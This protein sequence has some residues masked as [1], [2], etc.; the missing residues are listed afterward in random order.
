[1]KTTTTS[2]T[3]SSVVF[4][5]VLLSVSVSWS[6]VS[7]CCMRCLTFRYLIRS[8]GLPSDV[9]LISWQCWKNLCRCRSFIGNSAT[10]TTFTLCTQTA[11]SMWKQ[12]V[13]YLSIYCWCYM[14]P[15]FEQCFCIFHP[16]DIWL[17]LKSDKHDCITWSG[18]TSV[19]AETL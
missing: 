3:R 10:F 12:K 15:H 19:T 4:V 2:I 6:V 17:G 13:L 7:N 8:A 16:L 5:R 14:S 18:L 9:V 1:M 11:R